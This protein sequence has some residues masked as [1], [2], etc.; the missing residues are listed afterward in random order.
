MMAGQNLNFALVSSSSTNNIAAF[1]VGEIFVAGQNSSGF[2]GS[3]YTTEISVS[4]DDI[5]KDGLDNG[6]SIYPNPARDLIEIHNESN[7]LQGKKI[8]IYSMIGSVVLN[9]KINSKFIDISSLTSG[10]FC[11]KI[12]GYEPKNMIIIK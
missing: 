12:E 5:I 8:T 11:V 4:T 7:A 10:V 3:H 1:T 6:I 9:Q 2:L